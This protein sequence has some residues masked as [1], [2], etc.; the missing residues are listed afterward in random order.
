[1]KKIYGGVPGLDLDHEYGVVLKEIDDGKVLAN[2]QE[3]VSVLDCFRGSNLV[4]FP[5]C[6]SSFMQHG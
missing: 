1:M 2:S 3:G 5:V 6:S 4:S